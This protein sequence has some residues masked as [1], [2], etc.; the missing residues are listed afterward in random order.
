[1]ENAVRH[2]FTD[3]ARALRIEVG[4]RE[5]V[6]TLILTVGDDGE[7]LTMG[8]RERPAEGIGIG[9]TRARLTGLYGDAARLEIAPGEEGRGARVTIT[10]PARRP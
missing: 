8:D 6:G 2:G 3:P 10:I 9:H 7:G 1:V 5:A 4:A